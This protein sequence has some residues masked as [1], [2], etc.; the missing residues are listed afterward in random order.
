MAQF[1]ANG[2]LYASVY[3]VYGVSFIVAFQF[4]KRFDVSLPAI[5]VVASYITFCILPLAGLFAGLALGLI[6][7]CLLGLFLQ[8]IIYPRVA[9]TVNSSLGGLLASLGSYIVLVNLLSFLFGDNRRSIRNWSVAEGHAILG[10]KL[11]TIQLGIIAIGF[12]VVFVIWAF[13]RF[14]RQGK[15]LRALASNE[16]L[17]AVLG[18]KTSFLYLVA[19]II[20][21]GTAGIA[22]LLRAC[23]VDMTPNMG[24]YPYMMGVAAGVIGRLTMKGLVMSAF[25]LAFAQNLSVI[26]V[27]AKWQDPI[28]FVILLGVIFLRREELR[29]A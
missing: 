28:A 5:G 22:G 19:M 7:A 15:A 12:I 8:G 1:I 10:A 21:A 9:S 11:T 14:S 16:E 29:I 18:L 27:S 26:W 3:M 2:V 24:L 25:V 13:L 6:V 23:D 4:C 20:A 17:A